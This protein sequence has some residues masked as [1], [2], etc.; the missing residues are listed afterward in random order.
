MRAR[1]AALAQYVSLQERSLLIV[2]NIAETVGGDVGRAI[3][4][5]MGKQ[6]SLIDSKGP[7]G[8]RHGGQC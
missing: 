2:S 3:K 7:K 4:D 5:E 8:K 1:V 6:L